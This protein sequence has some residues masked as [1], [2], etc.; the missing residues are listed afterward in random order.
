M[1]THSFCEIKEHIFVSF[2]VGAYLRVT[3]TETL[4]VESSCSLYP[5]P[6]GCSS[7]VRTKAT[8]QVPAW[9]LSK[10][11]S[12]KERSRASGESVVE[13]LPM[14]QWK[15]PR[16]CFLRRRVSAKCL[17][18]AMKWKVTSETAFLKAGRKIKK[19]DQPSLPGP[20]MMWSRRKIIKE[21][22]FWGRS[23]ELSRTTE[24]ILVQMKTFSALE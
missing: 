2:S 17:L 16:V 13:Y 5:T 14:L 10:P 15:R 22:T 1:S 3:T 24:W 8:W 23:Q 7:K 6:I 12:M 11:F 21:G 9:M 20:L 19:A 4:L 18:Q